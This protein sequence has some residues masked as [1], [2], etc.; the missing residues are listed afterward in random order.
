MID[1]LKFFPIRQMICRMLPTLESYEIACEALNVA[2]DD[3]YAEKRFTKTVYTFSSGRMQNAVI[4]THW[5]RGNLHH[6]HGFAV[7]IFLY[8]S[9]RFVMGHYY[10]HGFRRKNLEVVKKLRGPKKVH[11]K[12]LNYPRYIIYGYMDCVMNFSRTEEQQRLL[13]NYLFS[14]GY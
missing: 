2:Y 14:L 7:E 4:K 9:N 13:E 1:G 10:T 11:R 8:R 6:R 5:F 3:E 12:L